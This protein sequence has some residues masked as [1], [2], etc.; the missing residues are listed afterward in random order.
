MFRE[1]IK[2]ENN[3]M[4]KQS[5]ALK[6]WRRDWILITHYGF[7]LLHDLRILNISKIII[8]QLLYPEHKTS[9]KEKI[10]WNSL[11]SYVDINFISSDFS[12]NRCLYFKYNKSLHTVKVIYTFT[13]ICEK[14]NNIIHGFND[15]SLFFCT[16]LT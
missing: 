7:R 8:L 12:L 3:V 2:W 10:F 6:W 1:K 11:Q 13:S 15:L 14:C 16:S 4:P 5:F 9:S